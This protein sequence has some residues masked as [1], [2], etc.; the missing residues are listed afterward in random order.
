MRLL[1]AET[2][3]FLV[4]SGAK[5]RRRTHIGFAAF[6]IHRASFDFAQDEEDRVGASSISVLAEAAA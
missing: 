4:L 5:R 2:Q 3:N 6:H 1:R